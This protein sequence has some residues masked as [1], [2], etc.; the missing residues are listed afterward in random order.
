M[1][2]Y[3]DASLIM[4]PSGY[5]EDKIYSLKPTDGS[6]DLTFTRASTAT[7]VNAE[8]LIEGVRTNLFPSGSNLSSTGWYTSNATLTSGQAD[9]NGLNTAMRIQFAAASGWAGFVLSGANQIYTRSLFIKASSNQ[10]IKIGE[11]YG[12]TTIV[13]NVTTSYQRFD[14]SGLNFV[15][16]SFGIEINNQNDN[17]A[18]DVTIAFVQ[19]ETGDVATEYIPTTTAAVSVGMTANIPRI[20]YTSGCGSLLLEKQSTNLVTYSEQFDNA[21]WQ[22]GGVTIAA[23]N[24]TSPDG[25]TNAE[26]VTLNTSGSNYIQQSH[27]VS[28]N[29]EYTFSFYAKKGTAT[30]IQYN[31]F[32]FSN[33]A[34]IVVPTNFYNDL[35]GTNWTRIVST[36]TTPSG[37]TSILISPNR[38]STSTGTFYLWGAQ[39]E[40]SSYATSYIPTTSTAVTRLADSASKTGISSLIG[41]TEGVLYAEFSAFVGANEDR[42]ISINDGSTSNR[43]T[44]AL[45]SNGTQIQ[46]VVQS[47]GSVVMNSTQTIAGLTTGVKIAYAYKLNDFAVYVNGVQIATDTSGAVPIS[48]SALSF[49]AGNASDKFFGKVAQILLFKTRLSNAELATLTTL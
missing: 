20:D 41:Q 16:G 4:Y 22:K 2:L 21:A 32:D 35:D 33:F 49:D 1:S 6:G 48:P 5:K 34:N 37:C 31:V 36:F 7:R 46:F 9:P 43:V 25:T 40:A 11:I 39:L 24:T 42:Q 27:S 3:D 23:N 13:I 8:G 17:A 14:V 29:T 28:A 45:L 26:L 47:G 44:M 38:D 19:I 10:S 12:G 18:K 15:S 30:N